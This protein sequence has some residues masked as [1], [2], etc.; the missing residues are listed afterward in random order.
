MQQE[1]Q[2]DLVVSKA[3]CLVFY[4][5]FYFFNGAR[6]RGRGGDCKMACISSAGWALS[7]PDQEPAQHAN[8]SHRLPFQKKPIFYFE[9]PVL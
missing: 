3:V 9:T 6:N 5:Y 4:F 2:K 7:E 1:G 8:W